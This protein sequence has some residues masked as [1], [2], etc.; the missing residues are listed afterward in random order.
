[1]FRISNVG[2]NLHMDAKLR[3]PRSHITEMKRVHTYEAEFH[4]ETQK[5]GLQRGV[6]PSAYLQ[7]KKRASSIKIKFK[8][9]DKMQTKSK[10]KH[11]ISRGKRRQA[12]VLSTTRGRKMKNP[13]GNV[14]ENAVCLW[15]Y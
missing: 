12:P 3:G 15:W 14:V 8:K 9:D 10:I 7:Q 5:E 2:S 6:E 1:M 13:S 11:K 4:D